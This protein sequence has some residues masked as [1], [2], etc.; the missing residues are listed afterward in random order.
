VVQAMP[1]NCVI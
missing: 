1:D